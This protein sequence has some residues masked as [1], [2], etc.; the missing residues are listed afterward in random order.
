MVGRIKLPTLTYIVVNF[1][2]HLGKALK[3]NIQ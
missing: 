2:P 3:V 1:K